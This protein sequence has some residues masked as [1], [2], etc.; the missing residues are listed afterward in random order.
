[1]NKVRF[2]PSE[3]LIEI[4]IPV[5]SSKQIEYLYIE[6]NRILQ[7]PCACA[8]DIRIFNALNRQLYSYLQHH[9]TQLLS[10]IYQSIERNV[11]RG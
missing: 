6:L 5:I 9:Y 10:N 4:E 3:L 8:I 7:A 2:I 11:Y 1:M